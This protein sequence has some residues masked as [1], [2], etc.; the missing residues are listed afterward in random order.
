MNKSDYYHKYLSEA[1][2]HR[3]VTRSNFASGQ[4][5][6]KIYVGDNEGW[7]PYQSFFKL[8]CSLSLANGNVLTGS[9]G[10]APNMFLGDSLFQSMKV[11]CNDKCINEQTDYCHPIS[12]LRQ[13]LNKPDHWLESAGKSLNFTQESIKDRIEQVSAD[14]GFQS[15]NTRNFDTITDN[16]RYSLTAATNR[17]TI[18]RNAGGILPDLRQAFKVGERLRFVQNDASIAIQKIVALVS[19]TEITMENIPVDKA[20]AIIALSVMVEKERDVKQTKEF[21]ILWK[22]GL[23]LFQEINGMLP[24]GCTY[25]VNLTP[26]PSLVLQKNAVET[27]LDKVPNTDYLFEVINMNMYVC[28][29]ESKNPGPKGGDVEICFDEIRCQ[30]QTLNT[31]SLT[32]KN[33][34]V[35]PMTH[36]LSVAYQDNRAGSDTRFSRGKFKIENDEDLNLIRIYMQYANKT[37]PNPIPDMEYD[38]SNNKDFFSQRYMET[39]LYSKGIMHPSVE[40][41]S[42]WYD[43]GPIYHWKWPRSYDHKHES[44]I[45]SQNFS[46]GSFTDRPQVLLFDWHKKM[47]KFSMSGNK[48]SG[49]STSA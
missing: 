33:Y 25:E 46:G 4:M 40:S 10:I 36:S 6:F 20:I 21:E 24:G 38:R 13:R 23:G 2:P 45:L 42:K 41:L 22:P 9:E 48:V 31:T 30:A 16:H 11:S 34:D 28:K 1:Q 26:F 44:V 18:T 29:Y 27:L 37:L 17:M 32:Q 49:V 19:A 15:L 7:N 14:G 43:R 3:D 8:R 5:R 12:V 47:V 35:H 39:Q